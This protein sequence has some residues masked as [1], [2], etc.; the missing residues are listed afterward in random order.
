MKQLKPLAAAIGGMMLLGGSASAFAIGTEVQF[1]TTGTGTGSDGSYDVT[2]INE[3]DWQS[4]GDLNIQ[5]AITVNGGATTLAAYFGGG[6]AAIGDN[7]V[8]TI[9]A[10]ARL[11]DM[12]SPGGGSIAPA[13]LDTNGLDGGDSGF[14]VT[15]VLN[16]TETATVILAGLNLPTVLLFTGISG[17][18]TWYYD[19]TPN[20]VVETGAGFMDGV[21][22]LT[23]NLVGASGTF[24]AGV[25]GS[26]LIGTAVTWYDTAYLQTD[27]DSNAPLIGT[28]F[29]TL[30][31][32]V[33][34]GEASADDAGDNIA[35][36]IFAAGD[37][38]LKADAN[39]EFAV[40][41]P[42]TLFLLGAGLLGLGGLARRKVA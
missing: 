30:V 21:P 27:P 25:G 19:A 41:E 3:F 22:I 33:S 31:S 6:G 28:S 11:N 42:G 17:T 38:G 34:T 2:N 35:G 7:V 9:N 36:H 14:E 5:S 29:D 23:A 10:Q 40:P 26:S 15:T 8:F 13:T 18:T 1:S 39:S 37:V 12:L 20:S 24:T 4:S 32:L 16:A